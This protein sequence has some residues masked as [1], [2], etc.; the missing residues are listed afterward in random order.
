[1]ADITISI[2]NNQVQRITTAMCKAG[3]YTGDLSNNAARNQFA[4]AMLAQY[5]KDIVRG[6][7]RAEAEQAAIA[8]V[9][10]QDVDVV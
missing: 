9:N 5:V 8:T 10:T 6:V 2:P 3:G 7:E 1:M 4:K